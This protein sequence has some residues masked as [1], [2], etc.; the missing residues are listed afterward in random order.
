MHSALLPLAVS[1][2]LFGMTVTGCEAAKDVPGSSFSEGE[3]IAS[4]LLWPAIALIFV[5]VAI[6]AGLA[7]LFGIEMK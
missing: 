1:G 5:V 3:I 6:W 4:A 7:K 2:Y